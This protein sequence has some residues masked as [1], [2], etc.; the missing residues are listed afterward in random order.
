MKTLLITALLLT[1]ATFATAQ[2]IEKPTLTPKPCTDTQN[3]TVRE[4]IKL[5][6]A[7]KY[8]E[9]VEKYQQVIAENP[10]CTLVL[11]E[12]TMTYY[13]MGEKT[14]SMETAYRGSKYKSED[15]PLF[16]M[17][18]ADVID[19]VGKPDEAVKIYRDAIK[20]LK[21]DKEMTHH[22]SSVYYNLGVTLIR[23]KKLTEAR[24]ELKKSI[25]YNYQ[26]A[27]PHFL[28]ALV[29]N[30]G[31]YKVPAFFAASRFL[32]LELTSQ[33]SQSAAKLIRQIL[34]PA[35]KDEK[36]SINIFLDMNAPKDEG[37]FAMFEMFLGTLTLTDD[38]EGEKKSEEQKFVSAIGTLIALV[39]ENKN[40]K[41]TFVGK[42]YVPFL[43][44][45]KKRGYSE[46]L[47]YLVLH[48]TGSEVARGWL[49]ENEA[50]LKEF[51]AWSKAYSLPN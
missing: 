49:T 34:A 51:I 28:L 11:Y 18:M 31:K 5:H 35:P 43:A 46:V 1:S 44:E 10:D 47:G 30:D 45:A 13:A 26:Y 19:D 16:Y 3:Q 2:K 36:G 33:R 14:K 48:H 24:A 40:V 21:D 50:K 38:K 37:D 20:M 6:D 22:L 23:Q 39:A 15:L 32:S 41:S 25:E 4:G 8:T 29:Y 42:T 27:S 9:A 7:K 17:S 12:L